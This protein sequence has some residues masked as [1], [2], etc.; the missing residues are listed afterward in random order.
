MKSLT[1][2]FKGAGL[3]NILGM[4]VAFAAIYVILVQVNYEWTFNK[5]IKDGDRIFAI[6][7][8]S[9]YSEGKFSQNMC[10]PYSEAILQ[11][12]PTVESYGIVKGP[13]T[14]STY[15]G[16]EKN[17]NEIEIN[18]YQMTKEAL[19]VFGFKPI[20]GS[21]D[22][23]DKEAKVAISRKI[24][25][26]F[27]LKAGDF[28]TQ[29]KE[30]SYKVPIVAIFENMPENSFLSNVEMIRC[31]GIEKEN[32]DNWSEWSY[33]YY[34]KLKSA[35]DKTAFENNAYQQGKKMLTDQINS[36]L[37]GKEATEKNVRKAMEDHI[38]HLL[39]LKD[40]YFDQAL[41]GQQFKGNKTTTLTLFAISILTLIITLINYV[42]F[43]MAQVPV[44]LKSV[45]TRKILGS[46]RFSLVM[47]FIWESAVL[48]AISLVIAI[49]IVTLFK[50]STYANLVDSPIDFGRHIPICIIT[51][52][53]ALL[54]TAISGLYPAL[55]TTSFPPAM[56]LK[57]AMGLPTHGKTFRYVLIGL[58]FT[59]SMAFII[60]TIFIKKQY[61]FMMNY[62]MGF[63][64]SM[65]FTA[66]IPVSKSNHE[67]FTE[68]LRKRPE[69]KDITWG[70]GPLIKD[71]RMK[72]G[73][74]DKGEKIS[75]IC[76]PVAYNFLKF[77]NIK[78]TDG[79][80]FTE[81]DEKC[82]KGIFIFN[83][84]AKKKFNFTLEDKVLGHIDNT[85]IAGFCKDFK[86]RSLQFGTEPF[87]FYVYGK[88][89][90][91][92]CYYLYIRSNP[93]T[94]YS[95]LL[96]AV[97]DVTAKIVPGYNLE[98]VKL[99]FFDEE[100]GSQYEKEQK[101]IKL[102]SIF[103]AIAIAIS[104]MG[105]IGI[106]IFET[107]FRKKEIAI[108]KVHGATISE[109]LQMFNK[110]YIII[111]LI[112]FVIATPISYYIMDYYYSTYAYHTQLY[113]WVFA[114]SLA[115]V[116]LTTFIVVTLCCLK[117]ATE[118]PAKSIQNE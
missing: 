55:Y 107:S 90:Q 32:I 62:D 81:A 23:M 9:M 105:I 25:E 3:L 6:T 92:F 31:D 28:I 75:F 99:D 117:T 54:M 30:A 59:I 24:A 108:R 95:D 2:L 4:S 97:K 94:T 74:E 21:F 76:Y 115:V 64:K 96:K 27:N 77:M 14:A 11:Q 49:V 66:E 88:L 22:G 17:L 58:Q 69:I 65:L 10:R 102:V 70:Q 39:P 40:M 110:K 79:R 101:L 57:G 37:A 52:V 78:I 48:V 36:N 42:N 111:Q 91:A 44:K 73:T 86:Y 72:W 87:A 83:E 112:C 98:E 60:C 29:D 51:V 71:S 16:T 53:A 1:K 84:T 15:A 93:N 67:A 103:T 46:S 56:A 12:S 113:W 35:N 50:N 43:F 63:N 41:E 5:G 104:I 34:V 80:N 85:D 38:M 68:E 114:V 118:N 7:Y 13:W 20:S 100:L 45:N 33:R 82:E 8:P 19:D 26:K 106:L 61:D 18:F 47:S 116:L 89:P 109:I